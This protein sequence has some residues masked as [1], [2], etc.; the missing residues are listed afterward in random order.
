MSSLSGDTGLSHD[1]LESLLT[2]LLIFVL[3]SVGKKH[4]RKDVLYD[5]DVLVRLTPLL[6]GGRSCVVIYEVG[7]PSVVD[8]ESHHLA[9]VLLAR[10]KDLICALFRSEFK[11]FGAFEGYVS[12]LHL[13]P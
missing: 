9:V 11:D 12:T 3:E 13:H 6:V 10:R 7:R 2:G 5:E 1:G 8:F 4:S